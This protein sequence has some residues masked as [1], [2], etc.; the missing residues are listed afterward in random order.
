M[1]PWARILAVRVV[2]HINDVAVSDRLSVVR[3]NYSI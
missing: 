2:V 1:C 3:A